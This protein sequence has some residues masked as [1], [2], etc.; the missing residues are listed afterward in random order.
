MP[1]ITALFIDDGGVLNDNALR[2][3]QWQ[4]L[5]AEFFV[6]ALGGDRAT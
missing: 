1:E 2:G 3:P 6:P 5:V 4:R